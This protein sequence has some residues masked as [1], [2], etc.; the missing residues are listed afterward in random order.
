MV[1][2]KPLFYSLGLIFI[3]GIIFI[4]ISPYFEINPDTLNPNSS[5]GESGIYNFIID[6]IN[7]DFID[8]IDTGFSIFGINVKIP[9]LNPFA[10]FGEKIKSFIAKNLIAFTYLP[11]LISIPLLIFISLSLIWSLIKLIVP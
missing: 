6:Y 1:N 8:L 9:I 7:A 5:L 3:I 10:L 11:D 4:L 2:Y